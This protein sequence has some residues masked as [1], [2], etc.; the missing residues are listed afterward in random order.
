MWKPGRLYLKAD[1]N[2]NLLNVLLRV[3]GISSISPALEIKSNL[4]DIVEAS[5]HIA[6]R[7]LKKGLSFAVRCR[8]V[9]SH[10]Y[11]SEDV[12]RV[13][14]QKIL[15]SF[16]DLDLRVNLK[17]P[18]IT[19][20]IEIREDRAYI[21][22]DTIKGFGGMPLGTQPKLVCLLSGGIDSPVACWMATRRGSPIIP[23]YFDNNPFTIEDAKEYVIKV[24]QAIFKWAPGFS[25]KMYIV[26]H[27]ENLREFMEKC[28]ARLVCILCKRMMYRVAGRVA[29]MCG[30]EGIVTGEIIGEQASQ[31][32]W[33][34]RILDEAVKDYPIYRP[35]LCFDKVEVERIARRIGTYEVSIKG[36]GGCKAAPKYPR[37]K[38]RLEEVFEAE[39]K[40]DI[41]EMVKRTL[42]SLKSIKL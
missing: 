11:K 8:R 33:N 18:D 3:F 23:L 17:E 6:K 30:A 21:Y 40:L 7:T 15:E 39:S 10:P 29:R 28:P 2:E 12:C 19:I 32:L 37:T 41:E 1:I 34:L 31:T 13:V 5:L 26:Q 42:E 24:A 9:G 4:D 16:P 22:T 35:L 36:V 25:H 38:A 27:G 14:G 20:G